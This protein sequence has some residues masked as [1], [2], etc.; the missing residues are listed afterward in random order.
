MSENRIAILIVNGGRD[1]D[2]GHWL[3]MC[4]NQVK[5]HTLRENYQVYVW[6]NN[7]DDQWVDEFVAQFRNVKLFQAD[8]DEEFDH[9]HAVPL[10]RLYEHAREDEAEI[11]VT[12]DSD[13]FPVQDG[14]LTE[15]VNAL[16]R[17]Y[18]VAGIWRDEEEPAIHAYIHASCLCTSVEYIES[19]DLRLDDVAIQPQNVSDTL[20]NFTLGLH[21]PELQVYMLRRSNHHQFH[22]LMNGIYGGLV[23]HH[24][25]GSRK[26]ALFWNA[27]RKMSVNRTNQ[28]IREKTSEILFNYPNE[29]FSWLK[30]SHQ[31]RL[32]ILFVLGMHRSGT[33]CL[34]GSLE[35][36]GVFFG[37]VNRSH[38]DN[39]RGMFELKKINRWHE[40]ILNKNNGSWDNIPEKIV[41]A[42]DDHDFIKKTFS[43]LEDAEDPCGIKDPRT[44]FFFSEWQE[45]VKNPG[46]IGTYRHP[47]AVARSLEQ[48]DRFLPEQSFTLWNTYNQKL[49]ELHR[50]YDFPLI[51]FNLSEKSNYVRNVAGAAVEF[52]LKPDMASLRKFVSSDLDNYP[53]DND[54]PVP[55]ECQTVY[56][57]L[58][59][60]K[61]QLVT[62]SF[63]G[64]IVSLL[65]HIENTKSKTLLQKLMDHIDSFWFL[66]MKRKVSQFRRML[67]NH[68]NAG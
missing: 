15:L 17:G 64:L 11:I 40:G 39:V 47:V 44:L 27:P 20:S 21:D 2:Q 22:Y 42:D 6:N 19:N 7:I 58:E 36:C 66:T 1:P 26:N 65:V 31:K 62:D 61:Y 52:G 57:Y 63:V 28:D 24:G 34:A 33:S 4:L 30:G 68:R 9:I 29:F 23:Y 48:R 18:K 56:Q 38:K 53:L 67:K 12:L 10:H 46:L 50:I 32:D 45:E 8:P 60:H 35:R 37:D 59:N 3:E 13:A 16:D 54:I 51:E 41:I 49:I 14:W 25:A 55:R 43:E 5:K